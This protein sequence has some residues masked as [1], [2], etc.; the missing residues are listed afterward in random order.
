MKIALVG[1]NPHICTTFGREA[2]ALGLIV[3]WELAG[4]DASD[5]KATNLRIHRDCQGLVIFSNCIS[6]SA[7]NNAVATAKRLNVPFVVTLSQ[8]SHARAKLVQC[9]FVDVLAM[10]PV[11]VPPDMPVTEPPTAVTV[12]VAPVQVTVQADIADIV[13]ATEKELPMPQEQP[14][15]PRFLTTVEVAHVLGINVKSVGNLIA[16]GTLKINHHTEH[17]AGAG[18]GARRLNMFAE[19]D[20]EA[21][22]YAREAKRGRTPAAQLVSS[23][24]TKHTAALGVKQNFLAAVDAFLASCAD[25]T[26]LDALR[27]QIAELHSKLARSDVDKLRAQQER[28]VALDRLT[29]LRALLE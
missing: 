22:L 2:L 24:V 12:A 13:I 4:R 19:A 9:G 14:R 1:G 21:L 10:R 26:E 28:D 18:N 8:W 27:S 3:C 7:C 17:D 11:A 25:N 29:K 5:A 16:R 15:T 20:V 6:H 23:M